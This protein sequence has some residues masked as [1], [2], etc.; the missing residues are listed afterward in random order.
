MKVEYF[1]I[2]GVPGKYFE[3][4]RGVGTM[5]PTA[6]AE[7]FRRSKNRTRKYSR[8]RCERCEIGALHLAEKDGVP[9]SDVFVPAVSGKKICPRCLRP[10]SRMIGGVLCVSCYNRQREAMIGVDRGRRVKRKKPVPFRVMV[11]K[12]TMTMVVQ[13]DA[14]YSLLEAAITACRMTGAKRFG[15][16]MRGVSNDVS[17]DRPRLPALRRQDFV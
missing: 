1:P 10:S 12:E 15:W 2:E 11:F 5:T 17:F 4:P 9:V 8:F 3:C 13:V 14:A 7:N 16:C 6:C